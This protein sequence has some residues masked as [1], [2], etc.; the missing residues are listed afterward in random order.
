M[1]CRLICVLL[2]LFMLSCLRGQI[3]VSDY[4]RVVTDVAIGNG[5]PSGQVIAATAYVFM[6][7]QL[8]A[9][10]LNVG[11]TLEVSVN[12]TLLS[13][14]SI[15]ATA[16]GSGGIVYCDA[17]CADSGCA[18]IGTGFQCKK[19]FGNCYCGK[20]ISVAVAATLI[21]GD[22][23]VATVSA[24][25]GSL[26]ELY[27][28]DDS[29]TVTYGAGHDSY[30]SGC[31]SL[32]SGFYQH[33]PNAIAAQAGLQGNAMT[34]TP[35]GSGYAPFFIPGGAAAL[36]LSPT[37]GSTALPATDDGDT[38][39]TPS[40]PFPSSAGSIP[41]LSV[42]H[43]GVVTMAATSNISGDYTPTGSEFASGPEA[44]FY[45]WHD[46]NDTEGIG[47]IKSE[48]VGGVLYITWENVENYPTGVSNP[49]TIQ[50]QFDLTTGSVT[51][52]WLAVDPSLASIFGTTHLIGYK[53]AGAIAD[54]GSINLT[55]SLPTSV[56]NTPLLP[57]ELS[58][59]PDPISTP[60]I[61]TTVV[62][63]TSNIPE[64]SAA[65]GIHV[66]LNIVSFGQL[67]A[68][69]LD[70]GFL[71]A[72]GCR[73]LVPTLDFAQSMSGVSNSMSV[74]FAIPAG[75]AP[76]VRVYSQSVALVMP[77]SLPNGQNAFGMT[78]SN[79][80]TSLVHVQ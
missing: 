19:A 77:Y 72:P 80:V 32:P 7:H 2:P 34:L 59:S 38:V 63:T 4:D 50:L 60:T 40:V 10:A 28:L 49:G 1:L 66:A 26:P 23:V 20:K 43:N 17:D 6:G 9:G 41:A 36:Y 79:G 61:G 71:G 46:Y 33:F 24:A 22:I 51:F 68:P 62:Y 56:P 15:P 30:G 64:V 37:A 12:G 54:L 21:P 16:V 65:S 74:S 48:E 18:N 69:G 78:T 29:K 73:A 11:M 53:A 75:I 42:S 31:Y 27:T 25:T 39:V 44:A 13:S 47:R 35:V 52:V 45:S 67:S 8:P 70:L 14:V 58:A 5:H 3:G 55:V 57:L 76:G